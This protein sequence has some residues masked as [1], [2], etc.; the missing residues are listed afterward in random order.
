MT[1]RKFSDR[2]DTLNTVRAAGIN[3]CCGGIL[4]LGETR[5]DRIE[6]LLP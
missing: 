1:T 4:G 3:V 2:L 5:E 6:F